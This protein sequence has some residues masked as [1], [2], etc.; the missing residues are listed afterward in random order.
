MTFDAQRP[1]AM[2]FFGGHNEVKQVGREPGQ[3]VGTIPVST[4]SAG[5]TRAMVGYTEIGD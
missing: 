5:V 4:I 1:T 3:V 2:I